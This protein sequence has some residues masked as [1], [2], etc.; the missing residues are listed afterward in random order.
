VWTQERT[1]PYYNVLFREIDFG[2][3]IYRTVPNQHFSEALYQV[4]IAFPLAFGF[5][6]MFGFLLFCVQE[7]SPSL[8]TCIISSFSLRIFSTTSGPVFIALNFS[9]GYFSKAFTRM[10]LFW[11]QNIRDHLISWVFCTWNMRN[12]FMDI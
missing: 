1:V 8:V 11:C 2:V 4:V 5:L 3:H 6:E 9:V 10:E 12:M 7:Q